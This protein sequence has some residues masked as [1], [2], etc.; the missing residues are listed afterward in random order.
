M[1]IF[2]EHRNFLKS[3]MTAIFW[4][5][6]QMRIRMRL[7]PKSVPIVY[8]LYG[9]AQRSEGR[10][11]DLPEDLFRWRRGSIS[12]TDETCETHLNV[13][14]GSSYSLWTLVFPSSMQSFSSR[15]CSYGY[16]LAAMSWSYCIFSTLTTNIFVNRRKI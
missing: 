15:R 8:S 13:Y 6:V 14:K 16:E 10:K 12:G 7:M 2:V 1:Y 11:N 4:V 9:L 5:N 3:K